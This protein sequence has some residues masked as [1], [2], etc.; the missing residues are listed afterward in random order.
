MH[1]FIIKKNKN[2]KNPYIYFHHFSIVHIQ[3]I[4]SFN[5]MIFYGGSV[6]FIRLKC[7]RKLI[8]YKMFKKI[9]VF[10]IVIFLNVNK[11]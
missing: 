6:S 11:I 4:S 7:V 2:K 1:I 3:L 5:D 10:K 8:F 9:N